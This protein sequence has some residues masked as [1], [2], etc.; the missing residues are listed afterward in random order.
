MVITRGY[1]EYDRLDDIGAMLLHFHS[2]RPS[3]ERLDIRDCLKEYKRPFTPNRS[4]VF[5]VSSWHAIWLGSGQALNNSIYGSASILN[6]TVVDQWD[7]Q[8]CWSQRS[9]EHC[10]LQFSPIIMIVVII[11][12]F[13]KLV[14]MAW[15]AWRKDPE[16]LVTLGD[17]IASFMTTEDKYWKGRCLADVNYFRPKRAQE[18]RSARWRLFRPSWK[19]TPMK[20]ALAR[21]FWYNVVSRRRR[22]FCYSM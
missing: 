5:L 8:Q 10:K 17:A 2:N 9:E 22:L 21:T 19:I 18:K 11:C 15:I 14:S 7:V 1:L 6:S 13:I 20:W 12:N 4:N 3:F 16:P